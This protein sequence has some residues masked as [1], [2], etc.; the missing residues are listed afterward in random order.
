MWQ[1]TP[2]YLGEYNLVFVR[3]LKSGRRETL[4]VKVRF[5]PRW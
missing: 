4:Q 2:G 1:S 5:G 3:T